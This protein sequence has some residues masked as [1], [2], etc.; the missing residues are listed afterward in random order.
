M[1]NT[2]YEQFLPVPKVLCDAYEVLEVNVKQFSDAD[3]GPKGN[4]RRENP[5]THVKKNPK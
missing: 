5:S 2:P 1:E 3:G 4:L